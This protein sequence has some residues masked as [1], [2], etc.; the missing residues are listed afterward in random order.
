MGR[1]FP[2]IM[3][4]Y[5]TD[6]LVRSLISD[7]RT[8]IFDLDNTII[9]EIDYLS[10]VYREVCNTYLLDDQ[11]YGHT[12]L[13]NEFK[14]S[15]RNRIFQKFISHFSLD[16]VLVEDLVH[17]L[18][19]NNITDK[20]LT[21]KWFSAYCKY[22]LPYNIHVRIITNGNPKQQ[23]KKIQLISFPR[24]VKL[25]IVFANFYVGKPSTQSFYELQDYEKF[26]DP[27]YIG[28]S[29]YDYEFSQNL[30]IDFLNANYLTDHLKNCCW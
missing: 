22:H 24:N 29:K 20:I 6:Y 11:E 8:I 23:Q 5:S 17:L 7:Q 2:D 26:I 16:S 25:E 1:L 10:L 28:D 4:K 12:W 3:M 14:K 15:G 18:R 13:L 27:I 21:K 9:D 30:G 19:V